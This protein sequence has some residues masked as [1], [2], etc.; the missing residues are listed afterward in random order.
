[1]DE[2]II[3]LSALRDAIGSHDADGVEEN[4]NKAFSAGL[5][6]DYVPILIELL[7]LPWHKRHEDVVLALHE[8]K[9]PNAVQALRRAA[10]ITYDYLDYDEFF[11]LARKCTWAL[12]D[13]GT[14]E[15]KSALLEIAKT[16]NEN[17]A[18]YARK[19]L[20]NWE[21]ERHRKGA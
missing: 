18:G 21:Q 14:I 2:S 11:G 10:M 13:I 12:A 9:P 3:V 15:A 5:T 16:E 4:L 1:M 7:E 19:R 17:I 6:A 20:Y 8:Q